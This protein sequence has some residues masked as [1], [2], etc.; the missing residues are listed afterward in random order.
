MLVC[1]LM[2]KPASEGVPAHSPPQPDHSC[3]AFAYGKPSGMLAKSPLA[4]FVPEP[5]INYV[6][7]MSG[8]GIPACLSNR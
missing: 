3:T 2:Q 4:R 8:L 5:S 1:Y 6:I 7:E